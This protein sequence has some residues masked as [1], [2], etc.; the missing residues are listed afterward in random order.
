MREVVEGHLARVRAADPLVTVAP[1]DGDLIEVPDAVGAPS[2]AVTRAD[3]VR[4]GPVVTH[5]LQARVA[6]D[7]P[8]GALGRLLDR[9]ISGL[10]LRAPDPDHR[11]SNPDLRPSGLGAGVDAGL[12]VNWPSR[13]TAPVAAL[14]RRGFAPRTILAVRVAPASPAGQPP[15]GT[16]AVP[17]SPGVRRAVADDLDAMC[18]LYLEL[19]DYEAQFGWVPPALPSTAAAARA[20]LAEKLTRGDGWCWLAER[21]G[22]VTGMLAIHHPS[23]AGRIASAVRASPVAYVG[24]LYARAGSRGRGTGAALAD[25]AHAVV[26]A[27]G[28]E[29]VLVHYMAANPLSVPFWSRQGYRPLVTTWG[30]LAATS[31]HRP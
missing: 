22:D 17:P 18:R 25:H 1:L 12:V 15:R 7:D 5:A 20:E 10:D 30:R 26:A 11:T 2:V 8:A 13:D 31:D 19:I 16:P 3:A 23:R 24:S 28:V 4:W 14:V 27:A 21:D 9:W 29:T 6:G